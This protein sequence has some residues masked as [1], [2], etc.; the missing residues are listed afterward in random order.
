MTDVTDCRVL[1]CIPFFYRQKR[2][3]VLFQV[4][5]AL[6][7]FN[8][9]RLHL[10]IVTNTDSKSELERIGRLCRVLFDASKSF[11]III[12]ESE[13]L[14]GHRFALTWYHKKLLLDPFISR[15]QFSHFIYMEDDL[16][17]TEINFRYFVK[18][19]PLLQDHGVVPGFL[20]YE[21]NNSTDFLFLPD[22]PSHQLENRFANIDIEGLRFMCPYWP[23]SAMFMFDQAM[24]REHA[25]SPMMDP[26]TSESMSQWGYSERA[27]AGLTLSDPPK[28][29]RFRCVIPVQPKTNVPSNM[30]RVFHIPSNYTNSQQPGARLGR[31]P[32]DAFFGPVDIDGEGN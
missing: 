23:Y 27:A 19:S 15:G 26:S 10:V 14:L 21:Y 31:V 11:E 1:V 20:R 32:L 7:A 22:F 29:F 2:L 9:D 30:C 24:A 3:A 13:F 4:L 6:A 8:V 28:N 5:K 12:P 18:F 16:E 25:A 17:V